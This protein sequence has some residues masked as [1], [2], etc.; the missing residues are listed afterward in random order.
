[1]FLIPILMA[2]MCY[3]EI[4]FGRMLEGYNEP[5]KEEIPKGYYKCADCGKLCERLNA[6]QKR[7]AECQKKHKRELDKKRKK[8]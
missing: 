7:C 8:K 3:Q 6:S 1:M 2:V 4:M 5:T